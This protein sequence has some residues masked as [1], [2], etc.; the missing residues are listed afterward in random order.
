MLPPRY[1]GIPEVVSACMDA[2]LQR[3]FN[4]APTLED[5]LGVDTW[6]RAFVREWK[7]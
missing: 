6:A 3:D 7:P 5:I 2:H 4:R 1:E